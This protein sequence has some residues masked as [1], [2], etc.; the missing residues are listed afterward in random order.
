MTSTS[1]DQI[2]SDA[3][4]NDATFDRLVMQL[5]PDKVRAS[6]I[7]L[8]N[9]VGQQNFI[10]QERRIAG[11]L[12]KQQLHDWKISSATFVRQVNRRIGQIDSEQEPDGRDFYRDIVT[13]MA[14]VLDQYLADEEVPASVLEEL[15]DIEIPFGESQEPMQ[16]G[17]AIADGVISI[18]N[19]AGQG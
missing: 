7:R 6:L 3:M 18:K 8:R 13:R 10:Q 16:L 15:L 5:G 17:D 12:T 9:D 1:L 4:K 14:L 11:E 2:T 19:D